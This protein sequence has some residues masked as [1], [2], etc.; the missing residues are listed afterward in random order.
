MKQTE[1]VIYALL[2]FHTGKA[3][4]QKSLDNSLLKVFVLYIVIC[5]HVPP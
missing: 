4:A 2:S 1:N 5:I 3:R